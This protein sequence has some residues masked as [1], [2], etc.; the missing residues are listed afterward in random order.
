MRTPLAPQTPFAPW[1]IY[2]RARNESA[3][4]ENKKPGIATRFF[5]LLNALVSSSLHHSSGAPDR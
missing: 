1:G 5:V 2:A 3:Y 4:T